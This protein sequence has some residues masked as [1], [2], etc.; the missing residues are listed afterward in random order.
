MVPTVRFDQ[1]YRDPQE[2]V[3]FANTALEEVR[4]AQLR[5][6]LPCGQLLTQLRQE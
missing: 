2:P 6:D 3:V 1:L 4:G 5:T